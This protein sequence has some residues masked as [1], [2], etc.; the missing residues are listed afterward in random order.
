[1]SGA[2]PSVRDGRFWENALR[3]CGQ[4]FELIASN[5]ANADTPNYK[6]RDIDFKAELQQSISARKTA[7][8][9]LPN[10][11]SSDGSAATQPPTPTIL[12]RVPF[13]SSV[14][15]N[16]VEVDVERGAFAENAIMYEFT[17]QRAVGEYKEMS[18][19][20]KSLVG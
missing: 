9:A 20:F 2:K 13:Q 15:G 4:R 1:M 12:Y 14:G 3:L 11:S 16:T 6:A 5:I 17:L 18:E 10:T 7:L 19:L 8:A